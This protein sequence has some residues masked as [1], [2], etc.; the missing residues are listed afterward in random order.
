[1]SGNTGITHVAY[2]PRYYNSLHKMNTRTGDMVANIDQIHPSVRLDLWGLAR[3]GQD[4][5][6]NTISIKKY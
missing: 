5:V 3:C 2:S 6:L 4:R 1:M